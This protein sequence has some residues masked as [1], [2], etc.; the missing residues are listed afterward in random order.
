[1]GCGSSWSGADRNK[2]RRRGEGLMMS[3]ARVTVRSE[4]VKMRGPALTTI[5]CKTVIVCARRQ[6][7]GQRWKPLRTP[8]EARPSVAV[9]GAFLH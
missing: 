4:G 6:C 9:S 5:T 1:M 3:G 2:A 7:R 8:M